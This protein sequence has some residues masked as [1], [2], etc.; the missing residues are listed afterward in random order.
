MAKKSDYPVV[1]SGRINL[2]GPS[3]STEAEINIER[4]LSK[5]NRRLYRQA[6]NYRVKLDID[7]DATHGY[8]VYALADNWMNARAMKMAYAMYLENSED[9]RARIKGT[10]IARWQDFRVMS[11]SG[12]Q[13]YDPAQYDDHFNLE[14][15]SAGEFND[16]I[17]VDA[18]NVTRYFTWGTGSTTTYGILS[19]YDKAGNASASPQTGTGDMPYDDLMAD[20]DA[21][22]ASSLQTRGNA[23]PYDQNGVLDGKQW[24]LIGVLNASTTAQKLSTGFFDAPCGFVLINP[25]GAPSVDVSKLTWTVQSGDYKGVHAPSMLE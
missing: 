22:M 2:S 10:N 5:T 6:R 4:F 19:E 12:L 1:R 24:V 7:T 25:R 21:A 20:D 11:G 15:L 16:T 13:K 18:Q 14:V 8:E 3:T 9:E 23:P 17:V